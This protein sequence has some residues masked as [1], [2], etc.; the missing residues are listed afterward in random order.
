MAPSLTRHKRAV[1]PHHG[2]KRGQKARG[3]GVPKADKVKT[4]G[5][6]LPRPAVASCAHVVAAAKAAVIMPLVYSGKR[7]EVPAA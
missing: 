4:E 6:Q 2:W 7:A 1:M 3:A 5:E